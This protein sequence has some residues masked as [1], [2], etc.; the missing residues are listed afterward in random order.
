MRKHADPN[1]SGDQTSRFSCL[2]DSPSCIA[3]NVLRLKKR[4]PANCTAALH[5]DASAAHRPSRT[6]D[7]RSSSPAA[8]V[9]QTEPAKN[10]TPSAPAPTSC[11]N[12]GKGPTRKQA[13][14][15]AKP[16]AIQ[17]S[18]ATRAAWRGANASA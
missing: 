14:P 4:V 5:H 17:R 13:E 7:S 2:V 16:M 1:T 11:T 15:T 18:Q 12:P 9:K 6:V 8:R 3:A 10:T